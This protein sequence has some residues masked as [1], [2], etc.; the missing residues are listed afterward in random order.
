ME[1]LEA[2]SYD[3]QTG[4]VMSSPFDTD[5]LLPQNEEITKVS[6]TISNLDEH[7]M[8]GFVVV[9]AMSLPMSQVA[10]RQRFRENSLDPDARVFCLCPLHGMLRSPHRLRLRLPIPS[11]KRTKST[12]MDPM[13]I[14]ISG[15]RRNRTLFDLLDKPSDGRWNCVVEGILFVSHYQSTIDD[16][17]SPL[18]HC[19]VYIGDHAESSCRWK[20]LINISTCSI[21]VHSL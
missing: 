20:Y 4:R 12:I 8:Y 18:R 7:S 2:W 21:N 17:R 11:A 13:R 3:Q 19:R 10:L 14:R 6:G 16:D 9:C 1:G 15:S 5:S